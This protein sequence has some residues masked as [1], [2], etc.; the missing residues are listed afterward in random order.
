ML[1]NPVRHWTVSLLLTVAAA[2]SARAGT[3]PPVVRVQSRL[4]PYLSV[5]DTPDRRRICL[6]GEWQVKYDTKARPYSPW[7]NR[8][9]FPTLDSP[10]PDVRTDMPM[11]DGEWKPFVLPRMHWG[12]R[13]S[14]SDPWIWRFWFRRNVHV[15]GM[16]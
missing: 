15:H 5:I 2:S 6:N 7:H 16:C 13:F 9:L 14:P 10:L 4:S 1:S 3:A 12:I 8:E 11:P